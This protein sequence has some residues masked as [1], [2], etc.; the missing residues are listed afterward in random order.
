MQID[1]HESY[2]GSQCGQ[3]KAALRE[4]ALPGSVQRRRSLDA[5]KLVVLRD[6]IRRC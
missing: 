4:R 3:L 5:E 6:T 1:F 2:S